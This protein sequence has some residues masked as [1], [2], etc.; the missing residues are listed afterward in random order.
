[1][2]QVGFGI[3]FLILLFGKTFNTYMPDEVEERFFPTPD[4]RVEGPDVSFFHKLFDQGG[5]GHTVC[6]LAKNRIYL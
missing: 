1:M 2:T 3:N 6:F 5:I 4:Y